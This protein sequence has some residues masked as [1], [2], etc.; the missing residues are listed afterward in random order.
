MPEPLND[1]SRTPIQESVKKHRGQ[2]TVVIEALKSPAESEELKKLTR[3]L[4]D[5]ARR[6]QLLRA[7]A[8]EL[9]VF[10]NKFYDQAVEAIRPFVPNLEDILTDSTEKGLDDGEIL[11]V[12]ANALTGIDDS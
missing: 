4:T 3:G 6:A 8:E 10:P 11:E 1:F 5:N 12:I 7:I 9:D 2:P